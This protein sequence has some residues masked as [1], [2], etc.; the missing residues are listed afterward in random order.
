MQNKIKLTLD[1]TKIEKDKIL[2]RTYINKGGV[3]VT[4]KDL[5]LEVVPLKE[6]KF[7][8]DTEKGTLYKTHFVAHASTKNDDGTWDN[9]SIIG[10]GITFE[11]K[12]DN[13]PPQA[14]ED[15]IKF[16]D[17]EINPNDIPF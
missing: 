16:P 13:V 5:N 8:K 12:G 14:R 3:E 15:G 4:V 2:S 10:D 11:P 9:G 17:D 1:V 7:I 6:K